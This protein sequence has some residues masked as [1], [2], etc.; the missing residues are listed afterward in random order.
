VYLAVLAGSTDFLI[1]RAYKLKATEANLLYFLFFFGFGIKV[2]IWP[3][4]Y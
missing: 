2:P 4:H 1:L 3:F